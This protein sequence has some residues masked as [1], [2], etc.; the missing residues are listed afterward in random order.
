MTFVGEDVAG[1]EAA[2]PGPHTRQCRM[3]PRQVCG[4]TAQPCSASAS[5][6]P[7]PLSSPRTFMSCLLAPEL[8]LRVLQG[9]G[10]C[11]PPGDEPSGLSPP[12]LCPQG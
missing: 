7:A 3:L 11:E 6:A 10:S 4:A 5:A 12:E 8:Q 9:A 1:L 2:E